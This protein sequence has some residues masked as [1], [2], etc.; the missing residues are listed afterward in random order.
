MGKQKKKRPYRRRRY[1]GALLD[2]AAVAAE[3]G[4][5]EKAWRAKIA[6]GE[7]PYVR[8]GGRILMRRAALEEYIAALE[9]VSV[10]DAVK[11]TVRRAERDGGASA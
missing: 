4:G 10:A 2:V 9:V 8:L 7:V 11:A 5:S 1:E 3:K 6:R